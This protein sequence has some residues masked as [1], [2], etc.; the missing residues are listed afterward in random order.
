MK[1]RVYLQ[2]LANASGAYA[3]EVEITDCIIGSLDFGAKAEKNKWG[4]GVPAVGSM[5]LRL[6]DR[7]GRFSS[8]ANGNSMFALAGRDHARVR[9]EYSIDAAEEQGYEVAWRGFVSSRGTESSPTD[10]IS[11][12]L[13]RDSTSILHDVGLPPGSVAAGATESSILTAVFNI[14]EVYT[15]VSSIRSHYYDPVA[16]GFEIASE[17]K[18]AKSG[19]SAADVLN[20]IFE[21]LDVLLSHDYTTDA[22]IAFSRGAI[23]DSE[24][25]FASISSD[26]IID[27]LQVNDGTERIYNRIA[28][29]LGAEGK[30]DGDILLYENRGSI[31][32]WG[33][34][35]LDL[36]LNYIYSRESGILLG[37]HLLER[38]SYP[39]REV[40]IK[41]PVFA[42]PASQR[43][44]GQ[45]I[46][47]HLSPKSGVGGTTYGV[48]RHGG[49]RYQTGAYQKI[50][51]S[52]YI[53]EL[54]YKALDD[55]MVLTLRSN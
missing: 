42:L 45:G 54:D 4:Y 37:E 27:L 18:F 17:A 36:D 49:S 34:N 47:L 43:L 9:V 6:A 10:G 8:E 22:V 29:M 14:P 23:S 31:D 48:G 38:L 53:H 35:A 33:L 46:D 44:I 32:R 11:E 26:D 52:Y 21:P 40:K 19:D 5:R 15:R 3:P 39:R 41:M 24:R 25:P 7:E 13:V 51:G 28:V 2:P 55:S 20:R 1:A 16:Q 12:L 50:S 30:E